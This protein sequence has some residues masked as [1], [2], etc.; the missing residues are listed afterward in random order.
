MLEWFSQPLK[1]LAA[2]PLVNLHLYSTR[3]PN[4][5]VQTPTPSSPASLNEKTKDT[6]KETPTMV[7]SPASTKNSG[8]IYDI[9]KRPSS[10]IYSADLAV[11]LQSERPDINTMIT[12]IV[13]GAEGQDRI[14]VAACGPDSLMR[15]TRRTVANN[16][17]VTG[18]SV[19]YHAEQFGW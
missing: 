7:N 15:V 2:S 14:I 8:E 16:I 11:H 13:E 3:T 18:P 5:S 1:E 12:E 9:E 17:K 4:P 19:E 10:P 6:P